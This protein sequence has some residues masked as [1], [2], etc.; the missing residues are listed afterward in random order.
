MTPV[1]AVRGTFEELP[2][3]REAG[4]RIL[5]LEDSNAVL[6]HIISRLIPCAPPSQ[7]MQPGHVVGWSSGDTILNSA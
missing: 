5:L 1:V 3:V 2:V 6:Q 7:A 4:V